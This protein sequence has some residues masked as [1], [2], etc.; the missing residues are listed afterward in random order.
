[1][2]FYNKFLLSFFGFNFPVTLTLWHMLV[3]FVLSVT[4]IHL[5]CG[6]HLEIPRTTYLTHILPIAACYAAALWSGNAAYAVSTVSFAQMVK[7]GTPVVTYLTGLLWGVERMRWLLLLDVAL[8][9]A[10]VCVSA[11]GEAQLALTGFALLLLCMAFESNRLVLTQQVV[12]SSE[13]RFTPLTTLRHVAPL[14]ALFLLPPCLV[15]EAAPALRFLVSTPGALL[16]L[17]LNALNAFALNLCV[18]LLI[19]RTSALTMNVSGLIKDWF[20]I[21]GSVVFL[22]STLTATNMA[23]YGIAFVGVCWYNY[24]RMTQ[25]S[26]T[27]DGGA[28]AWRD[29]L[30]LP[31]WAGGRAKTGTQGEDCGGGDEEAVG[32]LEGHGAA[33]HAQHDTEHAQRDARHAQPEVWIVQAGCP[34]AETAHQAQRG[35]RSTQREVHMVQMSPPSAEVRVSLAGEGTPKSH[36][37]GTS[38]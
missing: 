31:R 1:M 8:V 5:G 9:A 36:V 7:A 18:Y 25:P 27:T 12:Q 13:L 26:G 4:A 17:V 21:S 32:L 15:L 11:A 30:R 37:Q 28:V 10:G 2:L 16:H 34:A 24:L 23:G 22:G 35:T 14:A 33:Q 29:W 3:C 19:G 6:E 38:R 20:T